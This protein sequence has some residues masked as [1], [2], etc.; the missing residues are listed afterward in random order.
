ML[1]WSTN[2]MNVVAVLCLLGEIQTVKAASFPDMAITSEPS[3]TKRKHYSKLALQ[4]IVWKSCSMCPLS[5][6]HCKDSLE[7]SLP[8]DSAVEWK[9]AT[10]QSARF[11]SMKSKQLCRS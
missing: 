8:F 5:T 11:Q 4:I 9:Y 1:R 3:L 7:R 2:E 10:I 6:R